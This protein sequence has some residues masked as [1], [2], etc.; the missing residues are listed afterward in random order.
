[1][2]RIQRSGI[3][4]DRGPKM[5]P[6]VDENIWLSKPGGFAPQPKLA[7]EKPKGETVD[8]DT[9]VNVWKKGGRIK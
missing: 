2:T 8:Y 3:Q 7:N 5:N 4:G 1:M 9:L 6:C